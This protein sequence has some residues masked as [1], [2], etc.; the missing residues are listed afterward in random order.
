MPHPYRPLALLFALAACNP[1]APSDAPGSG[2]RPDALPARPD[3]SANSSFW[4][5]WGDG[6]AELNHYRASMERYGAPR[7][8]TMIGVGF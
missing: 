5:A 3:A 1:A 8:A 6:R 4:D 2:A 7:A